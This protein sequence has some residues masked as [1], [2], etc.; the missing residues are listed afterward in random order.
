MSSYQN[1]RRLYALS[2]VFL[3]AAAA[4]VTV[5]LGGD[6]LAT[7]VLAIQVSMIALAGICDLV[8]ATGSFGGW[9]WY[10]W[11]GLGNILLGLSLPLGF[12]GTAWDSIFLLVTGLGGLSLTAMGIDLV[13][14]HG[15]YTQQTLLDEHNQ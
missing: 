2:G 10:R 6:L 4:A 13:A 14:F 15:R 1:Q 5:L 7:S 8:A 12:V 11:G 3:T 9:A